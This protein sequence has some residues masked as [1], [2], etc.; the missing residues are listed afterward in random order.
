MVAN[1]EDHDFGSWGW[2][3]GVNVGVKTSSR[4]NLT[5]GPTVTKFFT[6]AQY[7]TSV[8]D[9]I[10]TPMYGRRYVF[11]PLHQTSVGVEARF[12]ITFTPRL[13]LETYMQ[14]LLSSGDYGNAKQLLAPKSFDFAPYTAP[15]PNLDFNLRSLRG[16]A[17]LRRA[18]R[19]GSTLYVAWQ[20]RRSDCAPTGDFS[21]GRDARALFDA[22]PDNILLLKVNYWFTPQRGSRAD[23]AYHCACDPN[24]LC[25]IAKTTIVTIVA[26][27][28]ADL[29]CC[30]PRSRHAASSHATPAISV[31]LSVRSQP[32]GTPVQYASNAYFCTIGPSTKP[33]KQSNATVA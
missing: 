3:V 12:N 9:A 10:F 22:R 19:A 24:R 13:S 17:V 4:W 31:L 23:A 30:P 5:V 6:P 18:W 7:V 29:A 27:I 2:N 28:T 20:Q 16:N 26:M 1:V 14:P 25:G 15:A 21:F 33:P 32:N 11:A 8:G